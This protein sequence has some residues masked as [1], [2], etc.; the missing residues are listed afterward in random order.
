M[1]AA[2]QTVTQDWWCHP[3]GAL[4]GSLRM[5]GDKSITQ[6]ALILS[7][8]ADGASEIEGALDAEDCRS[9][10]AALSALGARIEHS[11]GRVLVS[12]GSLRAPLAPLDLGNSGTGMRLLAGLLAGQPFR[13]TLTGDAS[14]RRR[15][16]RRIAEPLRQMGATV[17][18][19]QGRAP[20]TVS[21][22]G[23]RAIDYTMPV[24]SAQVKSAILIAALHAQGTTRVRESVASRDHTER[25]LPAL[26]C[27][28]EI[29]EGIVSLRGPVRL[30]P[31]RLRVPGDF[32]SAAFFVAAASIVPD[33][34]L[35]IE[36]VG[37]N[38]TRT[39]LL[40]VLRAMGAR[41]EV[42]NMR[43]EGGEPVG[44]VRVEAAPLRG[45]DV[46]PGIVPRTIDELPILFIVAAAARGATRVRG[47]AEL[48]LKESDRLASMAAGLRALG[49]TVV[50]HPDG[51]D[52]EGGRLSGGAICSQGDHRVAMAFAVAAQV[53]TAPVRVRDTIN[54]ATSFPDF[55]E[56]ARTAGF[57]LEAASTE[58]AACSRPP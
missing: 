50:E 20:L 38:P 11:D 14:L 46:D 30:R 2:S 26:G 18:T 53:A 8:L 24:P 9:T 22:G 44:D 39:G 7:A 17:E 56:L 49:I 21:G 13:A 1:N 12:G 3:A 57:G 35:E 37:M 10:A 45:I 55:G 15:P 29:D 31:A 47:A 28:P 25:M 36:G 58:D 4:R 54:V 34:T 40:D 41:I 32:S 19:T 23:L 48:R 27:V 42:R 51:L 5:P 33:S 16:M 43:I 52:I 6:R